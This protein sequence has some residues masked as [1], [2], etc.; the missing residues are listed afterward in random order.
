MAKSLQQFSDDN[1]TENQGRDH[2]VE[3]FPDLFEIGVDEF[4]RVA[5][6]R[7]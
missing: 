1:V 4:G 6:S 2:M 7:G 5:A 3:Q